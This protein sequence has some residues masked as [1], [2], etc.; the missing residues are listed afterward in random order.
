MTLLFAAFGAIVA[1]LLESTVIPYLQIN[2]AQPHLVFVL[3]VI[4]TVVGGFDRGLVFAFVGGLLLD[5]LTERPLGISA[6]ALLLSVGGVA[7]LSRV[8]SR[9]RPIVPIVATALLSVVYS[10][11]LFVTY[12][13]LQGSVPRGNAIALFLPGIVYDVVL[14]ALLGPLMVAVADRRAEAERAEW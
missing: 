10:M 8:M 9:A 6:F 14:A 5:V 12:T 4:V 2:G 11:S 3:A 7:V 13:A 1:A